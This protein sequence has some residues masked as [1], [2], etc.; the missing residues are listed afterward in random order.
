V[1]KHE[2]MAV[3]PSRS[4]RELSVAHGMLDS[5]DFA[6]MPDEFASDEG[7]LLRGNQA[8]F[9]GPRSG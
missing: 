7:N 4:E 6:K 2:N 1:E 9:F 5:I 3:G 8:L